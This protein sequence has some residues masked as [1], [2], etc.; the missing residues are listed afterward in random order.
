MRVSFPNFDRHG[1]PYP[2]AL[3][4]GYSVAL[5]DDSAT[6]G[7]ALGRAVSD[8]IDSAVLDNTC[9]YCKSATDAISTAD[10]NAIL[11]A[12]ADANGDTDY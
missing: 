10:A 5:H 12:F 2:D 1:D 4:N 9:P 6:F 7:D 8:A 3:A 11:S